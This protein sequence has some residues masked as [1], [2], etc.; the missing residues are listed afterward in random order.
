MAG[1]Q[2]STLTWLSSLTRS[3]PLS[4]SGDGRLHLTGQGVVLQ[5]A[6]ADQWLGLCVLGFPAAMVEALD[7]AVW[8][9]LP[10]VSGTCY[11]PARL[12]SG[13]PLLPDPANPGAPEKLH[14]P[15]A[16]F[17][18][19]VPKAERHGAAGLDLQW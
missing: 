3:W 1:G 9:C 15:G 11:S 10:A 19:T 18:S 5:T 17:S 4:G 7:G 12:F 2:E 16:L 6:R 13:T 14:V 8:G